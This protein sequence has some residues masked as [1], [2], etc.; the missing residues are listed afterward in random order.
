MENAEQRPSI[1]VTSTGADAYLVEVQS[2]TRTQHRVSVA[3]AYL[4]ELDVASHPAIRVI[5]EAFRFLLERE[6]NTS[7]LA[8]FE[9]REIE[10]YFPEFRAEIAGRF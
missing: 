7:I 4:R 6:P 1:L 9:L 8:S 3:P 10:R 5:E 2:A